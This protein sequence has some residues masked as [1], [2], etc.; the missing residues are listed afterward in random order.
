VSLGGPG[1]HG[2]GDAGSESSDTE[3]EQDPKFGTPGKETPG[4]MSFAG[5]PAKT[6]G[7]QEE[8][9]E[10]KNKG[11]TEVDLRMVEQR[12]EVARLEGAIQAAQCK[13][14]A[15]IR[16]YLERTNRTLMDNNLKNMPELY[17]NVRKWQDMLEPVLKEQHKRPDFDIFN[18]GQSMLVA[19]GPE[20]GT[21]VPFSVLCQGLPRWEVCRRFLTMLVLTNHG[22]TDIVVHKEQDRL[23]SFALQLINAKKDLPSLQDDPDEDKKKLK[24]AKSN[25]K[26]SKP[27]AEIADQTSQEPLPIAA[28]DGAVPDKVAV[29]GQRQRKKARVGKEN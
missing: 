25:K 2:A 5:T 19:M 20:G 24:D 21:P 4:R 18:Y 9:E 16:E 3:E 11:P 29:Q 13:Y 27:L 17:A 7:A 14:E 28:D 15:T 22:N 1:K 10:E 12:K 8:N 23:N 26:G 6:P